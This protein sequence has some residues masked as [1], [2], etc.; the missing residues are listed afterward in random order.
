MDLCTQL[1]V[2]SVLG[3]R[4]SGLVYSQESIS[5]GLCRSVAF[6]TT[7]LRTTATAAISCPPAS[8]CYPTALSNALRCGQ[9]GRQ[10]CGQ[11][12]VFHLS[13]HPV[14]FPMFPRPAR[15]ATRAD[16][17]ANCYAQLQ[18][19]QPWPQGPPLPPHLWT[20]GGEE[21]QVVERAPTALPWH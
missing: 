18:G 14:A 7:P 8:L 10:M 3:T 13:S 9:A 17:F 21:G 5:T 6:L 11:R 15:G 20:G 2:C 16:G 1:L 19:K 4:I 12:H